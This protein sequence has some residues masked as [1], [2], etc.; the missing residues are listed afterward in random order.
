VRGRHNGSSQRKF[1]GI[2]VDYF[3]TSSTRNAA[4]IRRDNLV[5]LCSCPPEHNRVSLTLGQAR[6]PLS[7][8]SANKLQLPCPCLQ[9]SHGTDN[10][11]NKG[12]VSG[13]EGVRGDLHTRKRAAWH[14]EAPL[15]KEPP[16]AVTKAA[17]QLYNPPPQQKQTQSAVLQRREESLTKSVLLQSS[18]A[19]M[20]T[21]VSCTN[22]GRWRTAAAQSSGAQNSEVQT[23][24]APRGC[25]GYSS[26]SAGASVV[27]HRCTQAQL[28]PTHHTAASI[29]ESLGMGRTQSSGAPRLPAPPA[30]CIDRVNQ[31]NPDGGL[32]IR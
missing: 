29:D 3:A 25:Q 16:L 10:V 18:R 11:R 28:A 4:H 13:R 27:S 6:V 9:L 31:G 26:V 23:H 17:S 30:K 15:K 12:Y 7:H 19:G 1:L 5:Q 8:S 20:S 22:L 2:R 14:Y 32:C 24:R 21:N